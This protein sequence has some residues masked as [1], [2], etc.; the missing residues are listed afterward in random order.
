MPWKN[1]QNKK[2]S[3]ACLFLQDTAA[4]LKT[5]TRFTL[6]APVCSTKIQ[7]S[8]PILQNRR[9]DIKIKILRSFCLPI[10]DKEM[11]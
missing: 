7:M 11:C 10:R 6:Q 2:Q 1:H 8:L 3:A 4:V 5:H 9:L